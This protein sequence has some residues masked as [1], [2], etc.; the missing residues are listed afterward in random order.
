VFCRPMVFYV[1]S[2]S[3]DITSILRCGS[4]TCTLFGNYVS[5]KNVTDNSKTWHFLHGNMPWRV[6]STYWHEVQGQMAPH[7]SRH[8]CFRY[9]DQVEVKLSLGFECTYRST[10]FYL[11]TRW[12]WSASRSCR[13]TPERKAPVPIAVGWAPLQVWALRKREKNTSVIW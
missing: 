13:F 7:L 9:S 12:K 4:K 10:Y 5:D 6:A 11:G 2:V 8:N 3:R 1:H